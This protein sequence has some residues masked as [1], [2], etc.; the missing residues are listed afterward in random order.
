MELDVKGNFVGIPCM[1]PC[2]DERLDNE[3]IRK[4]VSKDLYDRFDMLML[5]NMLNQ[6][7]DFRW[8]AHRGCGSGQIVDGL[9]KGPEDCRNMFMQCLV[10]RRR[11]CAF[12]RCQW[13]DERSC[14]DYDDDAQESDE[15]ALL[16]YFEQVDTKQCPK[17]RHAIEKHGGCDHMTCRK[18]VGGCGAEFCWLCMADYQGPQ[19][20]RKVG[21]TAH[22]PSC[23][24]HF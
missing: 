22:A 9:G 6:D 20:I 16:Q 21:N 4:A 15:V 2:C 3:D 7:P 14:A 13:H 24:Y 1:H 8:C 11:T 5:R 10:C 17:C 18:E 12:H 19:G 23:Q